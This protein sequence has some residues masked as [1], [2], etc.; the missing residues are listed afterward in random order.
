MVVSF[1]FLT[2]ACITVA[3]EAKHSL[4]T[5]KRGRPITNKVLPQHLI[6]VPTRSSVDPLGA[7]GTTSED[8]PSEDD[9]SEDDPSEDDPSEEDQTRAGRGKRRASGADAGKRR[10]SST[11][12]DV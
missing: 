2:I 8:D 7:D 1:F 5:A 10:A 9:P 4:V 3:L 11:Q 6:A 12:R